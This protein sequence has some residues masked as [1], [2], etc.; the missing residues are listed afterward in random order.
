MNLQQRLNEDS[1]A[2][3]LHDLTKDAK[4]KRYVDANFGK[5]FS[6]IDSVEELNDG[7]CVLV[8]KYI[9]KYLKND[10]KIFTIGVPMSYHVFVE[11]NHRYYDA[12]NA[13]GVDNYLELSWC[14]ENKRA[15]ETGKLYTGI[16]FTN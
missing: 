11:I 3:V 14:K 5:G 6:D 13:K 7:Y 2:F 16:K 15:V 1:H 10:A 9:K 8:A 12:V 4:F